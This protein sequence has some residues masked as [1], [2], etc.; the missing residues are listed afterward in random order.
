VEPDLAERM[1]LGTVN[2]QMCAPGVDE[3]L[4]LPSASKVTQAVSTMMLSACCLFECWEK[5]KKFL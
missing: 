3:A 4:T 5:K 2:D 1:M